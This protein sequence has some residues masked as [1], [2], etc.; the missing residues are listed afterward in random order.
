MFAQNTG[1]A[2]THIPYKGRAANL[3]A[4]LGDE[5]SFAIDNLPVYAP[6]VKVGTL[7]LLAVTSATRLV[8]HPDIPTLLELGLPDFEVS[9][10][11][12]VS[13]ATGTPASIVDK[14]GIEIV[15][16]LADPQLISKLRELGADAAPLAPTDHASFMESEIRK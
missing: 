13:A 3:T 14:V 2:A 5:I 1:V 9:S 6:H 16:S 12:G 8:S 11:F 4:L 15:A 10:W 7:K